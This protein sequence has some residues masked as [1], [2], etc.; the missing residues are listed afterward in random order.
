MALRTKLRDRKLPNYSRWEENFHMISHISGG[1]FAIAALVVCVAVAAYHRNVWG[2][3]SGAV[4]GVT[5]ILLYAMSSIYHGLRPEI[6]KKVFQVIDHCAIFLLIAGTYTPIA[7]VRLRLFYP[8]VAWGLFAF[9]WGVSV[10]GIVFNA[11]DLR[12][13]RVFS[14]ICYIGLG[15]CV[16]FFVK[17]LLASIPVS[18]FIWLVAGGAA[19]T[20][21]SVLYMLGKKRKYMHSVFHLFV[22]LGSILHFVCIVICFVP[23]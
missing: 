7:L 14:M 23:A 4:Y 6:P 2:M 15:W 1:V 16:V 8:K 19:Y 5:M 22:I 18:A 20:V 9:I 11:I 12:K 17:Q 10:L 13:F 21:G 3:V